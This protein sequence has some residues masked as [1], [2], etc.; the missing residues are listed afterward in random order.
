[1]RDAHHIIQTGISRFARAPRTS[2]RARRGTVLIVVAGLSALIASVSIAFLMRVRGDGEE[3]QGVMRDAQ[4]RIMLTAAC[5]WIQEASRLG[6]DDPAT[7]DIHEE[8]FGWIDV[9]DGSMGPKVNLSDPPRV[10]LNKPYRFPM[11]VWTRTKYAVQLTAAYNPI[12]NRSSDSDFGMPYLRNP[13]PQPVVANG[14]PSAVSASAFD[15]G[16]GGATRRDFVHG[17]PTPRANAQDLAWFRVMRTAPARFLVTCGAGGTRGFKT[18][19]EVQQAETS[20]EVPGATAIFGSQDFFEQLRDGETRF[21]YMV[22]WSPA[23]GGA[24]YQCIDNEQ[25]PDH[26]QWRPFNPVHEYYPSGHQ[27]QPHARN[28]VGTI[29]WAQRL[30]TEPAVW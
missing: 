16:V 9:R 10:P 22:E 4:A 19:N 11:W 26:Y 12:S 30:R 29:R 23:V 6:Y 1:M 7:P 8:A 3:S 27:S 17:D 21:W 20:G 5:D 28:M 18:W 2:T 13:D 15:D 24:T 25:S 14:W